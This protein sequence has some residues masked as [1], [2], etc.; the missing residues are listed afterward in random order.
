MQFGAQGSMAGCVVN[1]NAHV[2]AVCQ[3]DCNAVVAS[4]TTMPEGMKVQSGTVFH[5]E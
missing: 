5:K 3:I 1:H 2:M 4:N